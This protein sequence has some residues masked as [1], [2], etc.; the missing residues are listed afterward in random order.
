VPIAAR[1]FGD[2]S[3][4]VCGR[5][6]DRWHSGK[7]KDVFQYLLL[8]RGR[9]VPQERM[10]RIFWPASEWSAARTSLKVAVHSI[11]N[12]LKSSPDDEVEP[13]ATVLCRG[14]GYLL[15]AGGVWLDIHEFDLSIATGHRAQARND[16]A[17]ALTSYRNAVS[18]YS[19]DFLASQT[20]DWIDEHRQHYRA[21][22]LY[23]LAYLRSEAVRRHDH[24]LVIKLCRRILDI[25]PYQE[26]T[27]Q[28]MMLVHGQRGELGQ[29]RE[30]YRLCDRRFRIDLDLKPT[31][32]TERI[33]RNAMAGRLRRRV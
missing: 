19:G 8:N 14:Q 32:D 20:A 5:E 7:S 23:A 25:D 3:L 13:A 9:L 16:E 21:L 1:F 31:E 24:S 12:I 2:F 17:T 15:Q 4:N 22:A 29:V 28:T 33:F 27:Y 10:Y 30:W 11:R 18:L 26:D 6:V